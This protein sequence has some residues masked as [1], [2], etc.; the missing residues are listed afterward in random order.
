MK[1]E[2]HLAGMYWKGAQWALRYKIHHAFF[3]LLAAIVGAWLFRNSET[4]VEAVWR[5]MLV[6]SVHMVVSY[7]NLYYL[8]PKFLRKGEY[9]IYTL[10]L[11]LTLGSATF[12]MAILVHT[13]LNDQDLQSLVW[14]TFF[15]GVIALSLLFT[16]AISMAFK[17][18]KD[19]YQEQRKRQELEQL[20]LQTELKFLKSQINPHF[21]FNSLNNIYGLTLLKSDKASA[22]LLKLS[23]ILRYVLHD[24]SKNRVPLESELEQ[25]ENYFELEMLRLADS[26][27]CQIQL[28]PPDEEM[29]IEPMLFMT[30][31]E[32]AFK[33]GHKQ[34]GSP[35]VSC[36][37]HPIENGYVFRVE[38]QI[39]KLTSPSVEKGGI[40][41]VNLKKRLELTY[42]GH[43]HF[44][45]TITDNRYGCELS[46]NLK[47]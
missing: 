19:W 34:G 47:E 14:S 46:I 17:L 31:L 26:S 24:G 13:I 3:W 7:V 10:G 4:P 21:L 25:L 8:V 15:L 23:G 2:G 42:S 9:A 39:S 5:M 30:L 16:V 12:P 29:Y 41:L 1:F 32:N 33:H 45:T 44:Q 43:Y 36:Q 28:L 11:L 6:L 27:D 40:G 35:Q 37:G 38:N 20:Q 22:A 18:V